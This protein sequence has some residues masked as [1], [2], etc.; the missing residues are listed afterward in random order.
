[1][2]IQRGWKIL[3]DTGSTSASS[4]EANR[5]PMG[6]LNSSSD[7]SNCSNQTTHSMVTSVASPPN[8][9]IKIETS[10]ITSNA[11]SHNNTTNTNHQQHQQQPHNESMK[12]ITTPQ[13]AEITL[14]KLRQRFSNTTPMTSS[15]AESAM[16]SLELVRIAVQSAFDKEIDEMVKH[17]IELQ[18]MSCALLENA[19]SQYKILRYKPQLSTA[20]NS[21]TTLPNISEISTMRMALKRPALNKPTSTVIEMQKRF[22]PDNMILKPTVQ[23]SSQQTQQSLTPVLPSVG[24]IKASLAQNH[25]HSTSFLPHHQPQQQQQSLQQPAINAVEVQQLQTQQQQSH[26]RRQI[27]W[28][29]AH[30]STSTK[31]V[32][33]VQANQAFGFSAE[34]KE[35]LASKHPELIRYLPDTE[36][37]DWLI[38]QRIIPQ[39]NRNSR[40]LFL[41]YDEVCHLYQNHEIY[42]NKV[43]IDLSVMMT[44]TVP[45]FM[46]QKMKVF[47]VDLNIKS[48]GL[49]TN[50]YSIAGATAAKLH[51][52]HQQTNS[53]LRNALLLGTQQPLAAS[54]TTTSI[55][56]T[57]SDVASSTVI[58]SSSLS[59]PLASSSTGNITSTETLQQQK[60]KSS[61]LSS[62]H[63]TLTA[64]LNNSSS[65]SAN[66]SVNST[67]ISEKSLNSS[68]SSTPTLLNKLRK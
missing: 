53:H 61:N 54:T 49:I 22:F 40:F 6:G 55:V 3:S 25:H 9:S 8:S 43:C 48:R 66:T 62:S 10:P 46:I 14:Q 23:Q 38:N 32:L 50:S 16:R 67:A 65:T 68:S 1:M 13:M 56:A 45:D 64:L 37:R 52:P 60:S 41:I 4:T 15:S 63:A 17:F 19:K 39:Q 12:F 36:D 31:F 30:I 20:S 27:F 28:N 26:P 21:I 11:S 51:Q 29:T 57:T 33:D 47:F 58:A 59:A 18:K 7:D 44:F 2:V 35:R 34:G 42:K 5:S 24:T